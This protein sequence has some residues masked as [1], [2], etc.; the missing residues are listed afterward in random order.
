MAKTLIFILSSCGAVVGSNCYM[1]A[2]RKRPFTVFQWNLPCL[3]VAPPPQ[4]SW[5]YQTRPEV[6][7]IVRQIINPKNKTFKR[8]HVEFLVIHILAA[9]CYTVRK[10]KH[11]WAWRLHFHWSVMECRKKWYVLP[12]QQDCLT[13]RVR[14]T[15]E[16]DEHVASY[17]MVSKHGSLH[18]K[19]SFPSLY[20]YLIL[21]SNTQSFVALVPIYRGRIPVAKLL[22]SQDTNWHTMKQVWMVQYN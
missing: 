21:R 3:S 12:W 18:V 9:I 22:G 13:I 10:E 16:R 2:I 15:T 19:Q 11:V 1:N 6:K 20:L 14:V 17:L 8:Q 7:D 5:C 4:M